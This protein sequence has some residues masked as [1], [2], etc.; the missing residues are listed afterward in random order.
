[1]VERSRRDAGVGTGFVDFEHTH[2]RSGHL[3]DDIYI[4]FMGFA[5]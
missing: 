3:S 2:T 1:M 5:I 4:Y